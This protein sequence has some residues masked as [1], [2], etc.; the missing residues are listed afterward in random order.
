MKETKEK[1]LVDRLLEKEVEEI[2]ISRP[3][4]ACV[5]DF[6]VPFERKNLDYQDYTTQDKQMKYFLMKRFLYTA[7]NNLLEM[8]L[9]VNDSGLQKVKK[10][11][12]LVVEHYTDFKHQLT[13]PPE[14]KY[15]EVF[16]HRQENYVEVYKNASKMKKM[17]EA[18]RAQAKA[19]DGKMDE[20]RE[21]LQKHKKG[22]EEY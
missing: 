5:E 17:S 3:L 21:E 12:E 14:Y 13:K 22:T 2:E 16:L 10:N 11:L 1:S 20:V 7:Y 19:F 6:F 4:E 9:S 15:E 18:Y 8:D